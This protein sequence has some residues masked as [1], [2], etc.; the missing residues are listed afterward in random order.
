M[1]RILAPAKVAVKVDFKV[2]ADQGFTDIPPKRRGWYY[3]GTWST[4][5]N[6]WLIRVRYIESDVRLKKR[7][8]KV[9]E[10][11]PPHSR[12]PGRPLA[13]VEPPTALT[14]GTTLN[15]CQ[16]EDNK[17]EEKSVGRVKEVNQGE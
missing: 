12:P 8:D 6:R 14:T 15:E 11:I 17:S 1:D 4:R 2:V 10:K 9:W 5:E 16:R 3:E 7:W 13:P